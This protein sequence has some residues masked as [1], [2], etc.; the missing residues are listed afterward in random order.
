MIQP[1]PL[2]NLLRWLGIEPEIPRRGESEQ[3]LGKYRCFVERT[4]SWLHQF[5]R[6]CIRWDR[7]PEPHRAFLS[8]AAAVVCYQIWIN[9]SWF[10]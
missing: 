9:E 3:G 1:S 6:L 10:C 4:V 7:R 5:R 2:R 8:L